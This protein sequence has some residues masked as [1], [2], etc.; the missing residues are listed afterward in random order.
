MYFSIGAHE[1]YSCPL[2]P[3]LSIDDYYLEFNETENLER[4]CINEN[5]FAGH[6]G[7]TGKSGRI[8]RGRHILNGL[9][10]PA[11]AE[12]RVIPIWDHYFKGQ[13]SERVALESNNSAHGVEV[14]FRGFPYLGLWKPK[15]CAICVHCPLVWNRGQRRCRLEIS[16]TKREL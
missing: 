8:H 16:F 9:L 3:Y 2:E 13:K 1:A 14:V 5:G 12:R 11:A 10:Q 15:G 6:G 7:F 4:Y